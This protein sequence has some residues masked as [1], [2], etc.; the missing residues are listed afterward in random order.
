MM[1]VQNHPFHTQRIGRKRIIQYSL[2]GMILSSILL[3]Y[4]LDNHHPL[5]SSISILLF[6]ASFASGLG[7]VPFLLIS[8]LVP[9]QAIPATAS[10]ALSISW[11][12]SFGIASAFLPLRNALAKG[13]GEGEGNVFLIFVGCQ[14]TALVVISRFLYRK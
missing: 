13:E 1:A 9:P 14:V 5:L 2:L 4:G 12:M 11:I 7:P 8:E 10:L 3:Y 6:V